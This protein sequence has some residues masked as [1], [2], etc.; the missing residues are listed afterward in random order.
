MANSTE[1]S[2]AFSREGANWFWETGTLWDVPEGD[3]PFHQWV[4]GVHAELRPHVRDNCYVNLSTD[5][6]PEW[7]RGVWGRL[8]KYARLERAKADW[9]PY[10]LLRFNKNIEPAKAR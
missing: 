8:E 7:R 5:N 1:D 2:A 4:D 3:E 6:G 9:D 10:N